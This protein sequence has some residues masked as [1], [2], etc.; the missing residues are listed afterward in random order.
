MQSTT[1][2]T[3]RSRRSSMPWAGCL[4]GGRGALKANLP[5]DSGRHTIVS[6]EDLVL[7]V[8]LVWI[9]HRI[10]IDVPAVVV[11]V[12]VHRTE[13]QPASYLRPSAPLP[14]ECSQGC[15]VFGTSEVRQPKVPIL[16]CCVVGIMAPRTHG[17]RTR[18]DSGE[19]FSQK[20][21]GKT[22]AVPHMHAFRKSI[23]RCGK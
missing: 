18:H 14:F 11:P 15:I 7:V 20:R 19:A 23:S 9:R 17:K 21:G 5:R 12:R 8:P 6:G 22:V 16:V 10:R 3:L 4:V 2:N 1:R 13:H